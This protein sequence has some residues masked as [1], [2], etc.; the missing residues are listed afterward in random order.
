[1]EELLSSF[2]GTVTPYLLGTFLALSL[3][4][5]FAAIKNWREMKRSPYFFQRLQASKRLQTYLITSAFLFAI[6]IGVTAYA[7]QEPQDSTP[8]RA[9][10]T[11]SKVGPTQQDEVE[12]AAVVEAVQ[13]ESVSTFQLEDTE[14]P[15]QLLTVSDAPFTAASATLPDEFNRLEPTVELHDESNLGTLDFSTEISDEY[16]A[17]EPQEIFPEGFY[18]LYATFAYEG[19]ADGMV[20]SWIWRHNG[21]VVEGGHEVWAYGDEGPGYI[22]FNPEEGFDAGQYSLEVWVNGELMTH[23]AAVMNSVS[24]S[25]NN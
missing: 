6:T 20:W 16:E 13:E 4:A 18:T 1:M 12:P 3:A 24:V 5:S 9:I 15:G 2:S 11:H 25:A 19:L 14:N 17:V 8:R 21:E 22:Y 10:L 23:S 7:W